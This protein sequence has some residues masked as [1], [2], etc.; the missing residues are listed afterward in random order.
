MKLN[1]I[2]CFLLGGNVSVWVLRDPN[3][4]EASLNVV[5]HGGYVVEGAGV[6]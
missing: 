4:G 5:C 1:E 3:N 2:G 6:E